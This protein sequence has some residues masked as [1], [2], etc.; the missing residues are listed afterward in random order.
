MKPKCY[1]FGVLA[2]VLAG[3]TNSER[4]QWSAFGLDA[5]VSLY[6]GGQKVGEWI[7]TGKVHAE[8][9]GSGYYFQD[10]KTKKLIRITGTVVIETQ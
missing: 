10:S 4:A 5:K 3:C 1:I 2:L 6:S 8:G 7:S 9:S